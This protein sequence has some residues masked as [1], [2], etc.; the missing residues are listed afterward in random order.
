[1]KSFQELMIEYKKQMEKGDIKAAYK[2]L[3]DYIMGLRVYF[4]KNYPN[5]AVSGCL[6]EGYM[7]MTFFSLVPKSFKLQK[8]K[9]VIVFCHDTCRFEV[10]LSGINKE[11]QAKYLKLL[12]DSDMKKYRIP[13]TTEGVDSILEYV[14]AE[15]PDFNNLN[16]LTKQIEKGTLTFIKD[17]E[18]FLSKQ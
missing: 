17:I 7:D 14:V 4:K 2:G 11:I 12:K 8:L 6:Y 18:D 10:W 5:F 13:S 16:A 9:V 1:M 15:T 3:M